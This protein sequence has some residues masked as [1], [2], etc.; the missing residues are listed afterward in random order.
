MATGALAQDNG[1]IILDEVIVEGERSGRPLDETPASI[2]VVTGD[3]A[4]RPSNTNLV[5][6]LS[7]IPNVYAD[8]SNFRLPTIR[9]IEPTAGAVG[10]GAI[11]AGA[12][13]R[14]NVVVDG[15]TRPQLTSGAVTSAFGLWD[16][17]QIE[18]ARGPQ[19]TLGGRNSLAGNV[20]IQTAD[21]VYFFEAAARGVAFDQDGTFGGAGM[22][23][24]PLVADQVALRL[25]AE[26]TD[27]ESFIDYTNPA[28]SN[29]SEDY[30]TN[31]FERYRSKIL[32][33]PAAIPELELSFLA[34][35]NKT[36]G[37]VDSIVDTG[38]FENSSDGSDLVVFFDNRQTVLSP[39]LSYA[40]SDSVELEARYAYV[41]NENEVP[42]GISEVTGFPFKQSLVTHSTEVLI[43]A[44]DVGFL[45][46]GVVGVTFD[47][48]DDDIDGA[49]TGFGAFSAD[50]EIE[51]YGI[52]AEMD[53]ALSDQLAL[54]VGGRLEIQTESRLFQ[55]GTASG[56]LDNNE[57]V[58]I[59]KLGL[60]YDLTENV[61]LG[62]QYSEG[63]RAGGLDFDFLD[64]ANGFAEFESETLRQHEVYAR[65]SF[66][67]ERLTFNAS[68]FFYQLDDAQ[69][70]G[71]SGAGAGD[72]FSL[73]GNIPEVRGFGLEL[74]GGFD[75]GNGFSIAA[76]LGL[77][78]TE[79]EDAGP[80]VPQF[81]GDEAPLAPNVTASLGI[82]YVS[83]NGFNAFATVKHVGSFTDSLGGAEVPSFTTVDLGVGYEFEFDDNRSFRIDAFV[84]N[85]ADERVVTGSFSGQELVGRP[86]TFGISGTI[87]F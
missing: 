70:P 56:E 38:T 49:F 65:T 75:F 85:V 32:I 5:D 50:G 80:V 6:A 25:T 73:R 53:F 48:S 45:N 55:F 31:D 43:R 47:N 10:G 81:E 69:T 29:I 83:D 76:G 18:V 40:L 68:A 28:I 19:S 23:N 63:F 58:F 2:A 54:I 27:G 87:R 1:P 37:P 12:Q 22:L 77:L 74:D 9:G 82:Q 14:V 86:R 39:E 34:E 46:R 59:P 41:D 13:A 30:E 4:D 8:P 71:A 33:T 26:V 24:V 11:T 36:Q 35:V 42:E 66:L 61:T 52:Y 44:V 7:T 60:R 17:E 78:D 84:N 15:V 57:T 20:R 3:E 62:Y 67:E 16:T 64:P 72:G 21:P 79:I 51:N